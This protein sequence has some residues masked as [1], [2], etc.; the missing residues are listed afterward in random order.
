MHGL[1]KTHADSEKSDCKIR[2][3]SAVIITE[4]IEFV[5]QLI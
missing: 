1:V 3:H 2:N 4:V 5:K